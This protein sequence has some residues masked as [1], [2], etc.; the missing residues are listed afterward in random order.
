[1]NFLKY[2]LISIMIHALLAFLTHNVLYYL[3]NEKI[4]P[5]HIFIKHVKDG[6]FILDLILNTLWPI[7]E[8]I[9]IIGIM[10]MKNKEEYAEDVIAYFKEES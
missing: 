9:G 8:L 1:M 7:I 6:N 10:M 5:K 3:A 4:N 2:Y